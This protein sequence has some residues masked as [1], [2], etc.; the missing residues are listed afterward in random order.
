V[1]TNENLFKLTEVP[2]SLTV[3]GGGP[4]GLEMAAAFAKLGSEVS[5]VSRSRIMKKDTE[6]V[7]Q[8]VRDGLKSLGVKLFEGYRIIGVQNRTLKLACRNDDT[9]ELIPEAEYYLVATGR[10]PNTDLDLEKAG[11]KYTEAGIQVNRGLRTSNR[12][13]FAIGDCTPSPKFTHLA[14]N[15]GVYLVKKL[16]LPFLWRRRVVLPYV[17]FTE[18]FVATVG[19][20]EGSEKVRRLVIDFAD[21][22]RAMIE[23]NEQIYG[24]VYF[25][26]LT[27]R[28]VGASI[29]GEFSEHAINFFTLAVQKRLSLFKLGGFITPYPTYMNALNRAYGEF[30]RY[31]AGSFRNELGW[32][33]QRNA[34][35]FLIIALL[36]GSLFVTIVGLV[37]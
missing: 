13:I 15:Q 22:D 21:T 18:P 26:P 24:E 8:Y 27:G 36:L 6:G 37:L 11:I 25:K 30:L 5:V 33:L 28:I 7:V 34:A 31:Y 3:I 35:V 2:K 19:V 14:N 20:T 29:A 16:L 23:Q 12:N 9:V 17:T 10:V 4:I 32:F 1:L